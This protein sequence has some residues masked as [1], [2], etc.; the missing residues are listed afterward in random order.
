MKNKLGNYIKGVRTSKNMSLR[1]LAKRSGV[2][3][4]YLSQLENGKTNN[5]SIEVSRKIA[6]G[7]NVPLYE[8]QI[9]SGQMPGYRPYSPI[10]DY[11]NNADLYE[12]L[13]ESTRPRYKNQQLL[14]EDIEQIIKFIDNFI[15][16]GGNN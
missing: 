13:R 5:P 1:E 15:Y 12:I 16:K 10:K 11:I 4:S 6:K 3:H 8:F 14:K 2:S 7:L 9:R